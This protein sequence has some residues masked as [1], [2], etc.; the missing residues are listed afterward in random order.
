MAKNIIN[1]PPE[2]I[3]A[4]LEAILSDL[5]SNKIKLDS[6]MISA[7]TSDGDM[8]YIDKADDLKDKFAMIGYA[9]NMVSLDVFSSELGTLFIGDDDDDDDPDDDE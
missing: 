8:F 6:I 5:K 2:E 7:I 9:Q 4:M 3:E 1:F